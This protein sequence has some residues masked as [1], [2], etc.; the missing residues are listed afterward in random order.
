MKCKISYTVAE[1]EMLLQL[2]LLTNI[3]HSGL[4]AYRDLS[5]DQ[6]L[7]ICAKAWKVQSSDLIGKI[8]HQDDLDSTRKKSFLWACTLFSNKSFADIASYLG[9]YAVTV[10]GTQDLGYYELKWKN[11]YAAVFLE[12]MKSLTQKCKGRLNNISKVDFDMI[13]GVEDISSAFSITPGEVD[14]IKNKS[15]DWFYNENKQFTMLAYSAN[16]K[17]VKQITFSRTSDHKLLYHM[18][19]QGYKFVNYF[20]ALDDVIKKQLE[21]SKK[22]LED[23][24]RLEAITDEFCREADE[25]IR[26]EKVKLIR[27]DSLQIFKEYKQISINEVIRKTNLEIGRIYTN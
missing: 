16:G 3:D 21:I 7:D 13:K 25:L 24:K 27:E 9:C 18:Q 22:N 4:K 23:A 11:K 6:I 1:N 26:A 15:L 10:K 19:R 5:L 2:E 8:N 12:I 17:N 20:D 14:K